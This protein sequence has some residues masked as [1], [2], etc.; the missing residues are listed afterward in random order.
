MILPFFNKSGNCSILPLDLDQVLRLCN[1][2]AIP[3]MHDRMI[4]AATQVCHARLIS[5]DSEI[6]TAG[7]VE[8]I[9]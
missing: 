9:W 4:V 2:M 1:L 6:R 3:E 7:I 5:R 8:V